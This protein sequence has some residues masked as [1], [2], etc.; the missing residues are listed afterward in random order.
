MNS[1]PSQPVISSNGRFG[2]GPVALEVQHALSTQTYRWYDAASGG[3]LV[4]TGTSFTPNLSAT[5]TYYVA[6]VSPEGCESSRKAVTAGVFTVPVV[7]VLEGST[8]LGPGDQVSLS[9]QSVYNSYQWQR[10]GLSLT[11]KTASSLIDVKE[12]GY[13]RVVV[14][15]M[16][17]GMTFTY[18]AAPVGVSSG[19]MASDMNY[20]IENTITE[21]D[22]TSTAAANLLSEESMRQKVVYFDGLGRVLQTVLTRASRSK[23]DIVTP[24]TYDPLGRKDKTYLPYVQG[25]LGMYRPDGVSEQATFYDPSSPGDGT[26]AKDNSP[27]AV[28]EYEA[29]PLSRILEQGAPGAAWQ[30]VAGPATGNTIKSAWR[31]NLVD[32]VRIWDYDF[33][34]DGITSTG[35]YL[36]NT[37]YVTESRDEQESL[38][39]QYTDLLGRVVARKVQEDA[40]ITATHADAG[41][42]LTQYVYDDL[43]NLVLV[44]QPEGHRRL[45]ATGTVTLTPAFK[46][47]WC[48]RYKYDNRKRIIEKEVPGAGKVEMVYNKRDQVILTR[49]ANQASANPE[50]TQRWSYIKYDQLGRQVMTGVVADSRDRATMQ[51]TADNYTTPDLTAP[52]PLFEKRNESGIGYTLGKAFPPVTEPSLLTETYY[53]SYGSLT[54]SDFNFSPELGYTLGS[55]NE[56]LLGQ[57]TGT[58]TRRLDNSEWLK[59][60]TF[61]DEKYQ[62]IQVLAKNHLGEVDQATTRFNFTGSPE[63]VLTAHHK[64]AATTHFVRQ[65][66]TY[67]HMGRQ[68]IEEHKIWTSVNGSGTEPANFVLLSN[69]FYNE[70][71]QLV[72]KGLHSTDYTTKYETPAFLQSVDYRYNIRGWLTSVNSWDS[73]TDD[74][75]NDSGQGPYGDLF[76]LELRYNQDQVLNLTQAQLNGNISEMRWK[77]IGDGIERGYAY[78]Y[79]KANRL[80]HGL[81]RSRETATA[82]WTDEKEKYSI[83]IKTI[84]NA[85]GQPE[86]GY[87]ANGNIRKMKRFGLEEGSANDRRTFNGMSFDLVDDLTYTYK[88]N[89]LA[90]VN[91]KVVPLDLSKN[92]AGDF[93]DNGSIMN[94]IEGDTATMEYIYDLNGNMIRD[95]NKG[96]HKVIYNDMNLPAKIYVRENNTN[97]GY[98]TYS[99]AGDGRKLRKQV[100][101]YA[102]GGT[103]TTLKA[104]MDY[105]GSFVYQQDTVFAHTSEGRV[106]LDGSQWNYEYHI[107]DHLGNTRVAFAEPTTTVYMA[108]MEENRRED[109]DFYF[110]DYSFR[111][112]DKNMQEDKP[113]VRVSVIA[114]LDHTNK[115]AHPT[116]AQPKVVRL[117]TAAGTIARPS[118]TLKVMP[119]DKVKA[120]VHVK[121]VDLRHPSTTVN[122]N[123]IVA[124]LT[125]APGYSFATDAAGATVITNTVTNTIVASLVEPDPQTLPKASLNYMVWDDYGIELGSDTKLVGAQAA[126]TGQ[127]SLLEEHQVLELTVPEMKKAGY[128]MI[129]LSHDAFENVD[130]Y[131]DDLEVEHQR[132]ILVQENHYDPWGL[133][134]AGIERQ[135][136][137]DHLFQYNGKEKQQELGLNWSD[138]G[139]RMYDAQIGRWHVVDQMADKYSSYSSYNYALNN[140]I[141]FLDPDGNDVKSFLT[142]QDQK[143]YNAA[144]S[145]LKSSSSI[146]NRIYSQLESSSETYNISYTSN[147]FVPENGSYESSRTTMHS[148]FGW[149]GL[150][151][152]YESYI[153]LRPGK[154]DNAGTIAEEVYHAGQASFYGRDDNGAIKN[155]ELATEVEA[156][157]IRIFEG[158]EQTVSNGEKFA[159]ASKGYFEA[160]RSG[161]TK[162]IKANEKA[163]R[164]AVKEF[165]KTVYTVYKDQPGIN[166]SDLNNYNGETRYFDHLTK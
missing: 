145:Q 63:E 143:K 158:G 109:E 74:K 118:I 114:Q 4:H 15:A 134:L 50:N 67:D 53:D 121:Y 76:G 78:A 72:D 16:L 105:V 92:P 147:A 131:F 94:Y 97:K 140:P 61:Y 8:I 10:D 90:V 139:A 120:R 3:T 163:F 166:K 12:W 102:P 91:D 55:K 141:V 11:G 42:M 116:D 160:L 86:H 159:E 17:D 150:V 79:D 89:R 1:I 99:Y 46:E 25:D 125:N 35:F 66:F 44:I 73:E 59:A 100:F 156:K 130:I 95:K 49:D 70:L 87:D 101:E 69:S 20:V 47:N 93:R 123:A 34:T 24:V 151:E 108:T 81:Y 84:I 77:G 136:T 6:A 19:P 107:K 75:N 88:G 43:G 60:V 96:I 146:F 83:E 162:A 28:S 29:S 64:D 115:T 112:P 14:T 138:Y 110:N 113:D 148:L 2:S 52:A 21:K 37:L 48:F 111:V 56:R 62:P 129:E 122:A 51:A 144:V 82:G 23:Q 85:N 155:N 22:I 57:V 5:K 45:P 154:V 104:T 153:K 41:F 106:L 33:A 54:D 103:S 68:K 127:A 98:I 164:A 9:V 149:T 58:R 26:I 119:G 124:A 38:T 30:P 157:I 39:I 126:V 31:T 13:Y 36:P 32:E 128:V 165:A 142:L 65:K 71:G 135:N 7:T 80:T 133:N 137:P 27:F 132:G 40:T 18:T 152:K 117:N 161:D